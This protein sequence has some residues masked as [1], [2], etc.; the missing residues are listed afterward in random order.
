MYWECN[1]RCKIGCA[2]EQDVVCHKLVGSA[3]EFCL[4]ALFVSVKMAFVMAGY[5]II[6]SGMQFIIN[7]GTE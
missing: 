1:K 4:H 6:R 2:L 5:N 7:E 3:K